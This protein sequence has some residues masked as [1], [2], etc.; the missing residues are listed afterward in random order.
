MPTHKTVTWTIVCSCIFAVLLAA[1]TVPAAEPAAEH[2][3]KRRILYNSDGCSI[4]MFKKGVYKPTAMT[5][6]DLRNVV[7]EV[8][9]PGSQVDTF[10]M[11][12]N[13]QVT[14]WPSKAGTMIGS[15]HHG[16]E[17]KNWPAEHQQ[18]IA[19][20]EEFEAQ[21][22]DPY[23]EM[24]LEAK[25]RGREALI[26]IRMNDAHQGDETSFLRAQ[27]WV[28]H[29]DLRLRENGLDFAHQEV[30]D[31]MFGII[32]EAGERYDCDGL[33]MD[34][35]RF[36]YYFRRQDTTSD[37]V[38]LIN[39]LVERVRRMADEL[40]RRRGKRLIVAAR[41]PSG[42][43]DCLKM[44]CDPVTWAKRGW[45]DFLSVAEML[46]VRY[47]LPIKP[48]KERITSI[49]VYGSIEPTTG[50]DI[51]Q[52]LSAADFRRAARH[53]WKDGADGMYLFNFIMYREHGAA[54][55][56]PPFEVLSQIGDPATLERA[57]KAAEKR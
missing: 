50:P 55:R 17:R 43:E 40:G 11:C 48:W 47:D 28:D 57:D 31:Y 4:F 5:I 15:R 10:L 21:G 46:L 30:R 54:S 23:A 19:S 34:F 9:F 35:N 33:E 22:I 20:L 25:R 51:S 32:R 27:F 8:A 7:A 3:K 39:G 24:L 37:S 6:D 12:V 26:T 18:W 36:P 44:G 16:A 56:E 13:A 29:P 1:T 49:P 2:A 14:F 52:Y 38:A 42:Y 45:I 53:L 41:V